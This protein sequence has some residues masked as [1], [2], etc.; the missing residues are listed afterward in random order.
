MVLKGEHTVSSPPVVTAPRLHERISLWNVLAQ[1]APFVLA[2]A[3]YLAVFLVM[4]PATTG[5]EPHYLLA[6]ESIAYDGDVDLTNDYA[7]RD[8]TLRVV[9]V[10]P[11]DHSLQA[12]D[13]T[14]SGQL[15]PA[16]GV[17]L[18][19]VLAPFVALGGL[20][21]ARIAMVLI[22]ALLADQLYRLLRDLGLPRRYRF[23][24]WFAAVFCMPVLAFSS[25]IY[26]ELPGA[27]LVVVSL[28]IMVAGASNPAA[29]AL[30]STA[31][32]ALVWLHVRYSTLSIAVLLGLA[33]AACSE[34][35]NGAA[36]AERR[37]LMD[38]FR[39][40]SAVV[41]GWA[42]T[43][44]KRWRTV[45]L[46]LV[47]PFA[48]GL[49]LLGAAYQRWYGS[50]DPGAPYHAFS[51]S[52]IG[53]GGWDFW[54]T[55]GL[56]DLLNPIAG[57]I[58]FAPVHWLGFAALGCL[59]V[60]FGWRAAACL[61]GAIAYEAVVAS[62]GPS[63]G[64]GF[65]ARYPMI[66]IPLIA[67]PISVAIE[68]VRAARVVFFPLLAGSLVFAGA[69]V[70][71]YQGLYPVGDK[72]RIFGLRSTAPAFPTTLRPELPTSFTLAPGQSPPR[73][74]KVQGS[75]IVAK[76]GRDGPGYV[77]WG[78]YTPLKSGTYRATFSL[79]V[80][81]VRR[82]QPV[83]TIDVAGSPPATVFA[84]KAVTAVELKPG[85][86]TPIT[87]EFTTPGGYFTETRVYYDGFGTLRAGPVQVEPAFS[88]VQAPTHFYQWPLVFLWVAGTV[89]VGWLFIQVMKLTKPRA[90]RDQ[91]RT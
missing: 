75:L 60:R 51:N 73:T 52:A 37:G 18:S 87:L 47:V 46:P 11:L 20:T 29:I 43:F 36:R 40:A 62:V 26:P 3:A 63:I 70:A 53:S 49:G 30:G 42:R 1:L 72:Q 69:A 16:H 64:F 78:P 2:F 54:Y 58:P 22:A 88:V 67:I 13:Y 74:G 45:A 21:G 82:S 39:A 80:T 8:R 32:A 10:F 66:V 28:R 85:Q 33:V 50:P 34:R 90:A 44:V 79:G 48:I 77:L 12:A 17:G 89:L 65:P 57:W 38:R 81:G 76:A 84:Q 6:A 56:R 35:R 5:D 24:A 59:V 86:L 91:R 68:H 19:A 71:D 14:G 4:R 83:A 31:A 9:N 55:F 7:S 27:L 25:Q 15:R 23:L 41:L 61:A